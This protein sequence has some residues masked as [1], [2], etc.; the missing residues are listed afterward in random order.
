[1]KQDK[2]TI[3][4]WNPVIQP[5][6]WKKQECNCWVFLAYGVMLVFILAFAAEVGISIYFES[7]GIPSGYKCNT[8]IGKIV[9]SFTECKG[10]FYNNKPTSPQ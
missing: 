2:N 1:M 4:K 3:R 8:V 5:Y 6:G 10:T 7:H 9:S